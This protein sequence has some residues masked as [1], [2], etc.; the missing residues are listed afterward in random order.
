MKPVWHALLMGFPEFVSAFYL[1]LKK[2]YT[3]A[4]D[5]A[6]AHF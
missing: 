5:V 1:A 6:S 4:T 2:P 3:F